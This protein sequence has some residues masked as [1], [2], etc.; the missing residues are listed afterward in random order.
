MLLV[1]LS[2]DL[3]AELSVIG[4]DVNYV[5]FVTKL[6]SVLMCWVW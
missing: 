3:D 5:S 2:Y 1:G 4:N 6:S